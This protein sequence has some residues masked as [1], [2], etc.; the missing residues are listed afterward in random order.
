MGMEQFVDDYFSVEKFKKAYKKRI[1]QLV[2][3]SF[4]PRVQIASD[5]GAPLGKRVVGHQKKNRMKVC[6][7]GGSGKKQSAKDTDKPKTRTLFRGQ[8]KCPNCQEL[9]H[10][11]N[12][13]KCPLNGT[14]KRQINFFMCTNFD[15]IASITV[16]I[17]VS[18]CRKRK[19]KKNTIKG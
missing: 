17:T 8:F 7:E 19:P 6:L 2:D 1:E 14:K 13:L 15:T 9:G 5:V 10:R 16:L 12:S 3:M 4:W 11:K 18:M